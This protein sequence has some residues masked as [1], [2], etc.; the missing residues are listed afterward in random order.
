MHRVVD[1]SVD[2]DVDL[3]GGRRVAEDRYSIAYFFHPSRNTELVS[4]PSKRV[5]E[6]VSRSAQRRVITAIE[7]LNGRL[8]ATYGWGTE[9][10]VP[11]V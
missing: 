11:G 4:V 3:G 6:R 7:H 10:A 2:A 9:E 1:P 8:A 5:R